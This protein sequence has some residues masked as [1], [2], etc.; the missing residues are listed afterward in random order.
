MPFGLTNAPAF[1]VDLMNQVFREYLVKFVLVFIDDILIYSKPEAEHANHLRIVFSTLRHHQLRAKFSKCH[2]WREE[3]RFLGHIVSK[4]G[5]AVDPTKAVAVQ[6][7]K[8]P[9]NATEV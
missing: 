9:R 3:V 2:F 1:F 6:D 5:L 8:T 7:W 4:E